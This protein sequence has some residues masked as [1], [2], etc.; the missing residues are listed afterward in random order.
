MKPADPAGSAIPRT[1]MATPAARGAA[2]V[3]WTGCA[4]LVTA[5][6]AFTWPWPW[7]E[8]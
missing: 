1:R 5:E 3:E 4:Y 6:S 2:G 7:N 8:L